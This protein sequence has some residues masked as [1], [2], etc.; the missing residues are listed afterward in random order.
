MR[1]YRRGWPLVGRRRISPTRRSAGPSARKLDR[2][3]RSRQL[4]A[5]GAGPPAPAYRPALQRSQ[6]LPAMVTAT[7]GKPSAVNAHPES[8]AP[9]TEARRLTPTG[10]AMSLEPPPTRAAPGQ[11]RPCESHTPGRGQPNSERQPGAPGHRRAWRAQSVRLDVLFQLDRG[12]RS[13]GASRDVRGE[14]PAGT[15][16]ICGS[17]TRSIIIRVDLDGLGRCGCRPR[18]MI[19]DAANGEDWTGS[20]GWLRGCASGRDR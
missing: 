20:H 5:R 10:H 18:R 8:E 3:A 14:C 7:S 15:A 12:R 2:R 9:T 17:M 13:V 4:R 16:R 11:R 6:S 19:V 1:D